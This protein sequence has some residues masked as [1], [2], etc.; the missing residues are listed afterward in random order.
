MAGFWD[1]GRRS[2]VSALPEDAH[3]QA[4]AIFELLYD[5]L[6]QARQPVPA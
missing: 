3:A 1:V 2:P 4:D 5:A 6:R